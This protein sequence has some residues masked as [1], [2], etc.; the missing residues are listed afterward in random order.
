[1]VGLECEGPPHQATFEDFVEMPIDE[2]AV[3]MG[4]VES[5]QE[6]GDVSLSAYSCADQERMLAGEQP[7]AYPDHNNV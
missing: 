6:K 1:M 3:A 7:R 5:P 2:A 4:L